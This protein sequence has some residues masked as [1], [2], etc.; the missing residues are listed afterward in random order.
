V[1]FLSALKKPVCFNQTIETLTHSAQS[2]ILGRG[3]KASAQHGIRRN[4][5][6]RAA[7]NRVIKPAL[8]ILSHK[9]VVLY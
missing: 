9:D 5:V 8:W 6:G 2:Q 7:H 4:A 3:K 1:T